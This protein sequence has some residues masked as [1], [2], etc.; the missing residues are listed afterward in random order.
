[1]ALMLPM[2]PTSAETSTFEEQFSLEW[3]H[4]FGD[5][6]ITTAPLFHGEQLFV[7]TSASWGGHDLPSIASFDLNGE[8]LWSFSNSNSTQHDMSPFLLVKSGSGACGAW[9]WML[10]TGWSD[11]TVEARSPSDGRLLW[12]YHSEPITWGITGSMVAYED[13]IIIPTRS[14]LSSLCASTG[15]AQWEVETGLGWRNGVS[16]GEGSFYLGDESGM[17][18]A[19]SNNATVRSVALDDGKIRHAPL[20]TPAGLFVQSQGVRSSTVY[21][22][23]PGTLEVKTT[24]KIGGSPAI[25]LGFD[26][27]VL[28]ADSESV[29]LYDCTMNCT[30][31]DQAPFRS[32]GEIAAVHDGHYMLPYNG[33]AVGWALLELGNNS[34]FELQ[35]VATGADGY[36]T[37]APAFLQTDTRQLVAFGSDDGEVFVYSTQEKAV[38]SEPTPAPHDFNWLAQ[39][40]VFLLFL[41][42]GGAAIQLLRNQGTSVLKFLSVYVLLIGLLIVDDVALQWSEWIED[43]TTTSENKEPWNETWDESWRGTQVVTITLGGEDFTIGGFENYTNVFE[44]T[45]AACDE[46]DLEI[47]S[48]STS[49]GQYILAFENETGEG[50]EYTVD[51]RLASVSSD[52]KPL[53]SSSRVHWYP[54]EA[55]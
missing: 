13:Q 43:S 29:R 52:L 44:L 22:I 34:T 47:Q 38:N 32:N 5:V 15:A 17:L 53:D 26:H 33:D 8:L 41:S 1:M 36:S 24:M 37:A 23:D 50:W 6:Y 55:R 18:W 20:L 14:G 2:L 7:R 28:S 19:V 35:T 12:S 9:P 3:S 45:E 48:E 54:V 42:L 16:V 51:G 49:M 21:L 11:G 4:D 30:M 31:T 27:Y 39:G 25:P 10:I 40:V 46:L